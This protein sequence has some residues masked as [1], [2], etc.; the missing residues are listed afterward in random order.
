MLKQPPKSLLPTLVGM[1]A[2]LLLPVNAMAMRCGTALISKG[3][4]QAKVLKYCG[5]PVQVSERYGLRTG[6]YAGT[7]LSYNGSSAIDTGTKH[8]SPYGRYEVLVEEWVFNLGPNRLMRVITF[9][10][11]IVVDVDTLDYGYRD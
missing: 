1:L 8:Y 5:E 6:F 9:E 11:G 7:R 3:D 2:S 10:N 4:V